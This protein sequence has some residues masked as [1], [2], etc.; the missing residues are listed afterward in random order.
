MA[1]AGPDKSTTKGGSYHHGALREAL[2]DKALEIL[3]S[4]GVDNISLRSVAKAVGVS[5]TSTY[6]HFANKDG[7]LTAVATAGFLD[8]AAEI[9]EAYGTAATLQ[10]QRLE[11]AVAYCR[12]ACANPN[13]YKLM[14]SS[15]LKD[16]DGEEALN[17]AMNETFR[18]CEQLGRQDA[19]ARGA[20]AEQQ[21]L[22]GVAAWVVVH[23]AASLAIE[24][25]LEKAASG[26]VERDRLI[27][28]VLQSLYEI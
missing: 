4:D 16:K 5:H 28:R 20:G 27:R 26:N 3:A 12:F 6:R 15:F 2:V 13:L 19:E 1:K 24:G 7:L 9:E 23:G 14:F 10:E 18:R 21:G 22:A 25:I 11:T 8:L 17:N